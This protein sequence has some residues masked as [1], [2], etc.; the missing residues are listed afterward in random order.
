MS[1]A[2]PDTG[3]ESGTATGSDAETEEPRE[4][5]VGGRR[6]VVT[7]YVLLV[8]FATVAGV[9]FANVVD[10]PEPP[11]FLFLVSLPPTAAGFAL[12]GGLTVAVVLGV[13]LAAVVYV[14]RRIDDTPADPR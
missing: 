1:R 8:G 13:P 9:L 12:Y 4:S 7:L 2:D 10:N 3:S 14:S 11:A 6:S 5:A